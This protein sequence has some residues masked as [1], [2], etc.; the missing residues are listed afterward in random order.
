MNRHHTHEFQN[1]AITKIFTLHTTLTQTTCVRKNERNKK[2]NVRMFFF[3]MFVHVYVLLLMRGVF[4][5]TIYFY[6]FISPLLSLTW[7]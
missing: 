7:Y 1:K 3:V 5:S 2:K 6:L 4:D